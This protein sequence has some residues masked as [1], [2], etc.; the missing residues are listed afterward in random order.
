MSQ[1]V[2]KCHENVVFSKCGHEMLQNVTKM[3]RF[4]NIKM[5]CVSRNVTNCHENAMFS[6]CVSRNVTECHVF[7]ICVDGT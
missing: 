2:T 6:K 1:N 5:E 7:I 4:H 3:S